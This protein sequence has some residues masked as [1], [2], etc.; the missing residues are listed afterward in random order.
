MLVINELMNLVDQSQTVG[1]PQVISSK[2]FFFKGSWWRTIIP[3][4]DEVLSWI[5]THPPMGLVPEHIMATLQLDDAPTKSFM[6]MAKMDG[7]NHHFSPFQKSGWLL[8][9]SGG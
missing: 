7:E 8:G 6:T 5:L 1:Y 9:S 4:C 3:M 2:V